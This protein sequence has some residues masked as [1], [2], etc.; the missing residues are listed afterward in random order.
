MKHHTDTFATKITKQLNSPMMKT[1]LLLLVFAF[2]FVLAA[3]EDELTPLERLQ[4]DVEVLKENELKNSALKITGYMQP[5]WQWGGPGAAIKVGKGNTGTDNFSRFGVRR[6]RLKFE[7]DEKLLGIASG[8]FHFNITDKEGLKGATVQVKEVYLKV[9]DPVYM[10]SSVVAGVFSRPFGHEVIYSTSNIETPERSRVIT[11]LFP[12]ESDM[13]AMV[14]LRPSLG[15]P[16]HF[17]C[18]EGGLFAGNA[19][20]PETDDRM[21]FIGHLTATSQNL[22]FAKLG[23]GVS[24]YNGGVYQ[25]NS[26]VYNMNGD[27][28]VVNSDVANVGAFASRQYFGV[29]GQASFETPLGMTQF[30]YEAVFGSQPGNKSTTASPNRAALPAPEDTYVRPMLGW[31]ATLIQDIGHIPVSAVVKYDV[32]DPNTAVSGNQIGL[33]GS[34]TSATDIRYATLALGGLWRINSK[35]KFSAFYEIVKNETSTS[36]TSTDALK[37][38]TADIDDNIFTARLQF[39][40]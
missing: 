37:N 31:Y 13:G 26:N 10:T 33:D 30:R 4:N 16:L 27:K 5:Q 8:V 29:D 18:L 35:L 17:L 1:F 19:I 40:F 12:E 32:Y 36:L 21:D 23:L 24:Y 6:A 34:S 7:Y 38:F 20:N 28:F 2:P 11:T 9:K 14:S 22:E 15:S 3:Q 25:T 39:R